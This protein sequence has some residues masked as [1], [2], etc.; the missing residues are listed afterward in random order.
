CVQ[1]SALYDVSAGGRHSPTAS[2]DDFGTLNGPPS[3]ISNELEIS[4]RA[5]DEIDKQFLLRVDNSSFTDDFDDPRGRGELYR[6][7]RVPVGT[8][9][10][11]MERYQL[12]LQH[13]AN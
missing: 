12:A 10:I 11:P 5:T 6:L 7:K 3:L 13:M 9:E 4:Y 2:N 1:V 8:K